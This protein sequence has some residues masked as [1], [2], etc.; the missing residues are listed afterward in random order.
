VLD[1]VVPY[2]GDP[3][4]LLATVASVLAQS[5]PRWTLTV[6]DDAYPDPTASNHLR[7]MDDPRVRY[8]RNETNLGLAGN[9][10]RCLELATN[11]LVVFPGCDDLLGPDYVATV[12]GAAEQFPQATVVQPG[13]RVVDSDGNPVSTSVD[14]VKKWLEPRGVRRLAGESAVVGLMRGN[15]LYWPSLTFRRE[16]VAAVGFR[17]GFGVVMD[18]A[19][20]VDLLAAGG[21]LLRVPEVCFTY[22]RHPS[23][24]SAEAAVDGTRFAEERRY[25]SLAAAQAS[26]LGW[27]RAARA[28]RLHATSRA[29]AV[30]LLPTAVRSGNRAAVGE[31]VRHAVGPTR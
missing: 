6:V 31:M 5:D 12:S 9:F 20:V 30:A 24:A 4:R 8:V 18:L 15:W 21:S 22:R 17:E 27:S 28:A 11:E 10:R 2:W 29:H 16:A 13:V 26:R 23:S 1:I 19:L 7:A 3:S 25:Y 14:T